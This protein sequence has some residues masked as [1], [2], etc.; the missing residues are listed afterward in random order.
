MS[1]GD[2][3]D[4]LRQ[5]GE[6]VYEVLVVDDEQDFLHLMERMLKSPLMCYTV[7]TVRGGR[8]APGL[9]HHHPPDLVLLD[10]DMPD[11]DGFEFLELMRS[12]P[13]WQAAHVVIVS[14][15]DGWDTSELLTGSMITTRPI[16]VAPSEVLKWPQS[17]IADVTGV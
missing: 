10:L 9:M 16:G 7:S 11:M 13:K 8:E 2:L 6:L 12:N 17:L 14:G 1:H 4:T 15:Q 5:F 3:W